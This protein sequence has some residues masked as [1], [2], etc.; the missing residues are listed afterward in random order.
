MLLPSH[1]LAIRALGAPIG[2]RG[3]AVFPQGVLAPE[4]SQPPVCNL[5]F[6]GKPR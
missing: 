6:V 3:V 2:K 5:Q 1:L 4:L